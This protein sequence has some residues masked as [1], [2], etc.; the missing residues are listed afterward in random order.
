MYGRASP[1]IGDILLLIVL[2][3]LT[4][5]VLRHSRRFTHGRRGYLY[6]SIGL[7]L[8]T[9]TTLGD[10][11]FFGDHR[12]IDL[13]LMREVTSE[14]MV[15]FGYVPAVLAMVIG[16]LK[17]VPVLLRLDEEIARREESEL[18]SRR[19]QTLLLES[20]EIASIGSWSWNLST[21]RY[22]FAS[23]EFYRL[24]GLDPLAGVSG[25]NG[26]DDLLHP[27]DRARY[28]LMWEEARNAREPVTGD[29]RI[30]VDGRVRFVEQRCLPVQQTDQGLILRG[31]AQDVTSLRRAELTLRDSIESIEDAFIVYDEEDRVTMFNQRY[32]ELFS[33]IGDALRP[34]L[35]FQELCRLQLDKGLIEEARGCEE[36]WLSQRLAR[37]RDKD[38]ETVQTI[39]GGRIVRMRERPTGLGGIV[40]VRSDITE[41][42]NARLEAEEQAK[43]VQTLLESA[44]VPL[45]I[46]REQRLVFANRRMHDLFAVPQGSLI[47]R[48]GIE[49]FVDPAQL[50]IMN[51]K[52][53]RDRAVSGFEVE[54]AAGDGPRSWVAVNASPIRYLDGGAL[55]AGLVEIT[56]RKAA[57]ER[58]AA[59]ENRFRTIAQGIPVPL[60]IVRPT[61][62]RI[63]F[64]NQP[65]RRFLQINDTP[66]SS[67]HMADFYAKPDQRDALV[68]RVTADGAVDGLALEM[69]THTGRPVST[70][71]S[72]RTIEWDGETALFG[73]VLDITD[74]KRIQRELIEAMSAAEAANDSKSQFLAVMSHELRTPLNAILGFSEVMMS[75]VFGPMGNARYLDY[76][77]DIHASGQHLLSLIS[78]VLD[79]SRI[80]AGRLELTEVALAPVPLLRE[81]IRFVEARA[82]ENDSRILLEDRTRGQSVEADERC[83]KQVL[84]NLLSNAV[85]F[86]TRGTNIEVTVVLRED[87]LENGA[88]EFRV[89]NSGEGIAE[90]DIERVMQPFT[91]V[92]NAHARTEHGTGLG[93]SISRHLMQAHGGSL[94]LQS[95]PGKGTTAIARFP[96]ERV[97]T[98]PP[99]Q[100]LRA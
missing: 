1:V 57:E 41:I 2:L 88:M 93:L 35:T 53:R 23:S 50:E 52:L 45:A 51:D 65:F 32:R 81:L 89:F 74:Q 26:I 78:D 22:D 95:T 7:C 24:H 85:K 86:S 63:R 38:N 31:T 84:L 76:A 73:V 60:C 79:L 19:L 71:H 21:R 61:D 36:A 82:R 67:V 13:P 87:G 6:I 18:E 9:L 91:Q 16:F 11:V 98:L 37:R 94:E 29:F 83:V 27:E 100:S 75:E 4:A 54:V 8:A 20:Q 43:A 46:L 34:G 68:E 69:L 25:L 33:A 47:G 10:V 64:A 58:L 42:Y 92:Q 17:W 30:L 15:L 39:A 56:D 77:G 48:H 80:E 40:D 70:L 96:A 14:Q 12:L 97:G 49:F 55:F 28:N 44:P 59:S 99:A 72:I 5:L 62:G 66:L 90:E 3:V